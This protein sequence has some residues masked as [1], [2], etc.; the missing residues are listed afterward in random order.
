MVR[1]LNLNADRFVGYFNAFA[2][3]RNSVT[4]SAVY[5][6]LFELRRIRNE[7]IPMEEL[8]GMQ[9][10]MTGNFARSLER[11]Q[12]VANFAINTERYSLDKNYKSY[13]QTSMFN[14][15]QISVVWLKL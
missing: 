2:Q 6:F 5:Q 15:L 9:N 3:V 4:D 12:T 10:F 7:E 1:I 8:K 13:L 14:N 11:P